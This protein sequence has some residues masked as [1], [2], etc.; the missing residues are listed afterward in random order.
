MFPVVQG[1]VFSIISAIEDNLARRHQI[2]KTPLSGI[3]ALFD[4]PPGMSG[5]FK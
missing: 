3:F 2:F 4:F 1:K 5:I